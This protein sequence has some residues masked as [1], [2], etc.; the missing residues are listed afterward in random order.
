MD[1]SIIIPV[2]NEQ[3]A[4]PVLIDR[5]YKINQKIEI[6]FIDDGS[7]DKT[8]EILKKN[9]DRFKIIENKTNIGKGASLQKGILASIKKNIFLMDGDL[10]VDT[11]SIPDLIKKFES[12]DSDAL[13]GIRWN[14]FELQPFEINRLGNFIINEI[15]NFIYKTNFSDILCCIKIIKSDKIKMFKIKSKNFE[16]ESELMR[17]I[18]INKISFIEEKVKYSRR[19]ISEGKKLKYSDSWSILKTILLKN[20]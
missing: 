2:Y 9:T 16:I 4:L 18:A 6:I 8:N 15:F 5:L 14:R 3:K 11:K 13:I 7:T 17:I 1:Y 20:N 12:N 10:E 19:D